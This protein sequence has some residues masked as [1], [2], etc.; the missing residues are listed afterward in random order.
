MLSI[1]NNGYS[2]DTINLT[3]SIPIKNG[4]VVER[5]SLNLGNPNDGVIVYTKTN[6]QCVEVTSMSNGTVFK[7]LELEG[8]SIIIIKSDPYLLWYVNV[9]F[10]KLKVKDEVKQGSVIGY[11]DPQSIR[12]GLHLMIAKKDSMLNFEE[13]L[14][15]IEKICKQYNI[16]QIKGSGSE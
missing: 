2:T 4:Y 12:Y 6:S 1:L 8:D 11:L 5:P 3:C 9:Q 15:F 14:K 13:H 10:L 7:I 16:M